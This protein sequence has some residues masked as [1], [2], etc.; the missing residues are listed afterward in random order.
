[1]IIQNYY[2]LQLL[3]G[4]TTQNFSYVENF[5]VG[6]DSQ[7]YTNINNQKVPPLSVL[8][9]RS[10]YEDIFSWWTEEWVITKFYPY[11]FTF[12]CTRYVVLLV[13]I[14]NHYLNVPQED[15]I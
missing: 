12:Q 11:K 3:V 13:V 2:I 4:K 10:F 8:R 1:M 9:R 7:V 6:N 15:N 14:I 5:R